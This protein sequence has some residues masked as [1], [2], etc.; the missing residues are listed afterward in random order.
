[1]PH[2]HI[3]GE[4]LGSTCKIGYTVEMCRCAICKCAVVHEEGTTEQWR[5]PSDYVICRKAAVGASLL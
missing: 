3:P 4:S 2:D 1:M 5:T